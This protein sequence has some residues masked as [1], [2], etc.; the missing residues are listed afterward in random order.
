MK[1]TSGLV[2]VHAFKVWDHGGDTVQPRGKSTAERIAK[3]GGEIIPGTSQWVPSS[4]V[5]A[6]GRIIPDSAPQKSSEPHRVGRHDRGENRRRRCLRGRSQGSCLRM[7]SNSD[8]RA[9]RSPPM[10]IAGRGNRGRTPGQVRLEGSLTSSPVSTAQRQWT[11][12][13]IGNVSSGPHGRNVERPNGTPKLTGA[14][15]FPL[16]IP[17]KVEM[18]PVRLGAPLP[19][20]DDLEFRLVRATMSGQPINS[21]V[22]EDVVVETVEGLMPPPTGWMSSSDDATNQVVQTVAANQR[23]NVATI[24]SGPTFVA[25]PQ[26]PQ[27][28][29][30]SAAS[31]AG[32]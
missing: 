5:D 19:P 8:H 12:A 1:H 20:H 18:T 23:R 6:E 16:H 14:V 7:A 11:R 27:Q 32:P 24:Y 31:R 21:I 25:P 15:F 4:S 22:C 10:P 9:V 28:I 29:G 3:Y 2:E 17:A 26:E 30:M 13:K